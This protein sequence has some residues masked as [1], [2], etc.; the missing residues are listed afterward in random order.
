MKLLKY[1]VVLGL[2]GILLAAAGVVAQGIKPP[3][4]EIGAR[5]DAPVDFTRQDIKMKFEAR[6]A[7]PTW[8]SLPDQ[9][10][11]IKDPSTDRLIFEEPQ[12]PFGGRKNLP[13]LPQVN[14]LQ[15]RF[16]GDEGL[17]FQKE[18]LPNPSKRT[19]D[20]DRVVYPDLYYTP[21]AI[22]TDLD[23]HSPAIA[24]GDDYYMVIF[25]AEGVL[26]GRVF[27][28]NGDYYAGG[29]IYGG[30]RPSSN[31]AV[32]YESHTGLFIVVFEYHFSETDFDIRA[33][34]VS[35]HTGPTGIVGAI[36][37]STDDEVNPD[38]ACNARTGSCLL[39]YQWGAE[40]E[41]P[42]QGKFIYLDSDGILSWSGVAYP[43][44]SSVGRAPHLAWGRT[45]GTY[46]LTYSWYLNGTSEWFPAYTHLYDVPV[47][48]PQSIYDDYLLVS[49]TYNPG[50]DKEPL[51]A[52]YDSCT[53]TYVLLWYDEYEE[54][55]KDIMM[56]VMDDWQP[57]IHG[58]G[59][60]ACSYDNEY[61]GDI[62]FVSDDHVTPICGVTD[63]VV[64]TYK[65]AQKGV[66]ATDLR[67]N[68]DKN[69]PVYFW[70]FVDN[71]ALIAPDGVAWDG[72]DPVIASGDH[73]KMFIAWNWYWFDNADDDVWGR[74]IHAYWAEFLPLL[75]R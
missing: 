8:Q 71:H 64:V 43:L 70:D 49:E 65:N 2:I 61:A 45:T 47:A 53:N 26:H 27:D 54:G 25:L 12:E 68:N 3:D 9:E 52:T 11:D 19:G 72:Y 62:S 44:S 6:D 29:P 58:D 34:A 57:D 40:N 32:V 60:V 10:V 36:V 51:S 14:S 75:T 67:G 15:P 39:A 22:E 18:K 74:L 66:F 20:G 16:N 42:I 50:F 48:P 41:H 69:D 17:Q 63:K 23:E 4:E 35:P 1:V 21:I 37:Q 55:D 28:A 46:F 38:I 13:D 73:G 7:L 33:V 56:A 5:N 30:E 31:P 24:H 59:C